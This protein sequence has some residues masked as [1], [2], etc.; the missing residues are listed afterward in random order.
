MKIATLFIAAVCLTIGLYSCGETPS[1]PPPGITTTQ[2]MPLK[3]GNWWKY[4]S[5]ECKDTSAY[6]L[7]EIVDYKLIG[8][9]YYYVM[10]A[11][12]HNDTVFY[13]NIFLFDT[14]YWRYDGSRLLTGPVLDDS[15]VVIEDDLFN[16]SYTIVPLDSTLR[17]YGFSVL[18]DTVSIN[19]PAGTFSNCL[20][21]MTNSPYPDGHTTLYIA[22]D[23]GIVSE[24]WFKGELNLKQY[25]IVP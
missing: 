12:V 10:V 5:E 18:R 19:V 2:S 13:R 1:S 25:H 22:P 16:E 20:E 9:H 6:I 15:T 14:S 21:I 4:V 24:N 23:I 17:E 8:S 11:S 3:V 7:Q